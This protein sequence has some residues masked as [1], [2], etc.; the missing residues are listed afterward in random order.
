MS[1]P[2]KPSKQVPTPATK[3]TDMGLNR[4][5]IA[6]SPVDTEAAVEAASAGCP[7]PSTAAAALTQARRDYARSAPPVGTMPP[8][9]SVKGAVKAVVGAVKGESALVFLDLLGERLAF[10]R[11]GTRLYDALLVKLDAADLRPGGPTREEVEEIRDDEL[12]HFALLQQ[13][14]ESLGGDPTVMTPSADVVG[15]AGSGWMQVLADPRTTL[16]E[17]LKV[18]LAAELTDGD[19]WETLAEV[20]EGLEQEELAAQFREAYGDEESHLVRVKTW[21]TVAVAGQAGIDL[22]GVNGG[23]VSPEAPLP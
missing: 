6:T 15:V 20:A 10:E 22:P 16:T 18:M 4:S 3:P 12:R 5:G 9:A 2:T 7:Q 8:P 21:V 11:T 13:A 1:K 14:I 19:A 17:A 23:G